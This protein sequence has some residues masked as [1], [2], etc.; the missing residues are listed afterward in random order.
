MPRKEEKIL[1]DRVA[2]TLERI[3][4]ELPDLGEYKLTFIGRVDGN[5]GA[6]ILVTQEESMVPLRKLLSR[7]QDREEI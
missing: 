7:S 2:R 3:R 5:P 4:T 6:D 1:R